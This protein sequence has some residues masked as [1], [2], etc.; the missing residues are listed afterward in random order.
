MSNEYYHYYHDINNTTIIIIIIITV[1]LATL[2]QER[3]QNSQSGL[4]ALVDFLLLMRRLQRKSWNVKI[5]SWAEMDVWQSII[6]PT[7]CTGTE[8]GR[9]T[10]DKRAK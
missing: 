8:H 10:D 3:S 5:D 7:T 9:T 1:T 4:Y 6:H 2:Y